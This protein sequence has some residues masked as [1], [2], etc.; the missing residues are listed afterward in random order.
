VAMMSPRLRRE[1]AAGKRENIRWFSY[2]GVF[3]A[4]AQG[5]FFSAVGIA[6]I[7]VV[8]PLLQFSLLFRLLFSKMFNPD[9][10]IFGWL[11]VTGVATS[12]LGS[13]AVSA[14]P[15]AIL[16]FLPL[17]DWFAAALRWRF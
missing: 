12:I 10:E 1:V 14:D 17:P 4:M 2:S 5:F 11:V 6:P 9:H 15:Y 13:L 8:S 7:M 16:R 3:V